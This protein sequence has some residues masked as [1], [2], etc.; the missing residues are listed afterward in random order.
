MA[1]PTPAQLAI[2]TLYTAAFNRAPDAAGFDYWLQAYQ[3]GASL[4]TLSA[5]FLGTPEGQATFPPGLS[6][7]AFV[8][9]FYSSVFGRT[10]DESGLKFWTDALDAQ[11]GAGSTTA[12][13]ALM[14]NIIGVAST[15][16]ITRP[17]GLSDAAYVQ[18]VADRARFLNK[19]E[20]GVYFATEL[21]STNLTLAKQMLALVSAD[22]ASI[23]VARTQAEQGGAPSTPVVRPQGAVP[24]FTDADTLTTINNVLAAYDGGAGTAD[25][26]GMNT[27][28]LKAL[29]AG[30]AVF[31]AGG[32]TGTLVLSSVVTANEASALL[33]KYS[34]T[35][36]S[37]N[38][39]GMN[40]AY[41]AV[42]A[43]APTAFSANSIASPTLLVGNASLTDTATEALLAKSTNATI[44][45]SGASGAELLSIANHIGNIAAGGIQGTFA[46]VGSLNGT[47]LTTLFGKLDAAARVTADVSLMQPSVLAVLAANPGLMDAGALTG[48]LNLS[49]PL[50]TTAI[51]VLLNRYVGTTATLLTTGFGS[52]VLNQVAT[53]IGKFA[54]DGMSGAPVI[55]ADVSA[56]NALALLGKYVGA[57]ATV[58]ASLFSAAE[59]QSLNAYVSK[60][61]TITS[62]G[63]TLASAWLTSTALSSF[64]AVSAN[65]TVNATGSNASQLL[66]LFGNLSHL[67]ND[68][69]SGDLPVSSSVIAASLGTL[70]LKTAVAANV[71]VNA[72]GMD[73]DQVVLLF[74][75]A[76]KID[77][78]SNLSA[79]SGTMVRLGSNFGLLFTKGIGTAVD[80]T[81]ATAVQLDTIGQF[82]NQ[83]KA[84]GLT[85]SFT[86]DKGVPDYRYAVLL[87]D[88]VADAAN[89]TVQAAGMSDAQLL[90]LANGIGKADTI[91]G[92]SLTSANTASSS[93]GQVASL[94]PKANGVDVTGITDQAFTDLRGLVADG[95]LKGVLTLGPSQIVGAGV[96]TSIDAKLAAA[97]ASLHVTGTGGNDTVN[98]STFTKATYVAG[99]AGADTITLGSG[100]STVFIGSQ[101]ETH[102]VGFALSSWV[103]ANIDN[104]IELKSGDVIKLS[105]DAGVFGTSIQFSAGT[106]NVNYSAA[107]YVVANGE[108]ND[109]AYLIS[110]LATLNALPSTSALAQVIRLDVSFNGG[111]IGIPGSFI[112]INDNNAVID[113]RDTILYVGTPAP[114]LAAYVQFGA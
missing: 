113:E 48:A 12:K 31:K 91:L 89:V 17:A 85:G 30:A 49:S 15:P 78:L 19:A 112:I 3:Q 9:A 81:G 80:L 2:A 40:A 28:K 87:G 68:G 50:T 35:T 52:D 55:L 67:A 97:G 41:L 73:L 42:L 32:L 53:S 94:L 57:S 98:L 79:P 58:N 111:A 22:P 13:A 86:I 7:Q 21:R 14:A 104:I 107:S 74:T 4:S 38:A 23:T 27:D 71:S 8:A 92:L 45:A 95:A 62:P 72:T 114:D 93:I 106:T 11:G 6:S 36:A 43:G 96:L 109:F 24:A 101:T 61:T 108:T 59:I 88:R 75:N 51:G 110:K 105:T 20:F 25:T 82:G 56:S 44:V 18:T 66:S 102:G 26:T 5:T 76:D 29:A 83:F 54:A 99:G 34:G 46:L 33:S 10:V 65:A 37:A 100:Q 1:T 84:D 90:A 47:Q 64:L 69:I 103:S 16:I 77:S 39:I 70:F 60:V 63:L